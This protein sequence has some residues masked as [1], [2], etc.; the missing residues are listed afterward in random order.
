MLYHGLPSDS[1]RRCSRYLC[2]SQLFCTHGRTMAPSTIP[3]KVAMGCDLVSAVLGGQNVLTLTD[4]CI[5]HILF[6][7]CSDDGSCTVT[8]PHQPP[9]LRSDSHHQSPF[10]CKDLEGT[11]N[12]FGYVEVLSLG[13]A[14]YSSVS[15]SFLADTRRLEKTSRK[16]ER[17]KYVY[18]MII[19]FP[20]KRS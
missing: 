8:K 11:R 13:A 14:C 6:H 17:R 4:M 2:Y 10:T 7:L 20:S 1:F 5:Q 16:A 18:R 12:D 3:V 9:P 19:S 15:L